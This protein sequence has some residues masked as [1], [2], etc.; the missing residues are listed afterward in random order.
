MFILSLKKFALFFC[1]VLITNTAT[2]S[3]M[4]YDLSELGNWNISGGP[5]ESVNNN[6][7]VTG[8]RG[9]NAVLWQN[10]VLTYLPT[11]SG[12]G[13]NGYDINE[14]GIIVGTSKINSTVDHAFIGDQNGIADLG[15]LGGLTSR[16][17][18]IN[19]SN[20]VSGYSLNSNGRM[21]AFI[22]DING[23]TDLGTLGGDMSYGLAIN[24]NNQVAGM[25][26]T[27]TSDVHAFITDMN[28]NMIDLGTLGGT[29]S[30]ADGI[31]N[32]GFATGFSRNSNNYLTAFIADAVNGMN[33][34]GTLGGSQSEGKSI[35]NLGQIT[36]WGDT[37][38]EER[39]AM[40]WDDVNGMMDLNFLVNDL[41]GWDYLYQGSDISDNG[42]IVGWGIKS[43]GGVS[44]FLLTPNGVTPISEPTNLFFIGLFLIGIGFATRRNVK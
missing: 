31:N 1:V 23:L 10:G 6:G 18:G 2:A 33:S 24:D 19:N 7:Q 20:K 5:S 17:T 26:T 8:T 16:G 4:T 12:N 22:G 40:I 14:N 11:L 15:T 28:G 39:H 3:V 41:T 29:T 42:H 36:G 21:R 13:S 34:I 44:A 32:H 35:N 25:S 30:R 27:S 9:G 38:N 43:A 37:V